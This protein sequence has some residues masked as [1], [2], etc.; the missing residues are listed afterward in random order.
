MQDSSLGY[1]STSHCIQKSEIVYSPDRIVEN[2]SEM[3]L[4]YSDMIVFNQILFF[5]FNPN[6]NNLD[7]II[8][9]LAESWQFVGAYQVF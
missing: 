8:R 6:L 5:K 4:S 1:Q 3:R 2:R 7:L 9:Y